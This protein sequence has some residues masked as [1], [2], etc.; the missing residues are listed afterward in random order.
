[1]LPRIFEGMFF[2]RNEPTILLV[3]V[4]QHTKRMPVESICIVY[5]RNATGRDTFAMSRPLRDMDFADGSSD[6]SGIRA[7]SA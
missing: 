2:Q 3:S 7:A 6:D 4:R 5:T 1:M